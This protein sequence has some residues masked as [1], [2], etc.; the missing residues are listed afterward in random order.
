MKLYLTDYKEL[1]ERTVR[2]GFDVYWQQFQKAMAED[3]YPDYGTH[4]LGERIWPPENDESCLEFTVE[5]SPQQI[6]MYDD[7]TGSLTNRDFSIP[8]ALLEHAPFRLLTEAEIIAAIRDCLDLSDTPN[9][10]TYRE[11][12]LKDLATGKANRYVRAALEQD[13][14]LTFA[15]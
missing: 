12:A 4:V 3:G 11:S 7:H 13:G 2:E 8:Y 5:L 6:E 9:G 15:A 10:P 1:L 14:H